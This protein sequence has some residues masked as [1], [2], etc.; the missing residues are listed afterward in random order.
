MP[1]KGVDFE[2]LKHINFV[3]NEIHDSNNEIY[4]LLVEQQYPEL[5]VEV[6]NNIR[7]LRSI[8]EN[9]EDEI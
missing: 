6:L 3:M 4:E 8:L 7:M 5:R 9:M 2:R 1:L